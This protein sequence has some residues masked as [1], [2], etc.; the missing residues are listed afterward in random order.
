[1]ATTATTRIRRST[2]AAAALALVLTGALAAG[3]TTPAGA[4]PPPG[5]P[6]KANQWVDPPTAADVRMAKMLTGRSAAVAFKGRLAGIV[7]DVDSGRVVWSRNGSV[8]YMPASTNKLITATNALSTYGANGQ[9]T[10]EVRAGATANSVVVVGSGDPSLSSSQLNRLASATAGRLKEAGQTSA[11]VYVDDD[12]FP[13]PTLAPGWLS[14][15]VPADVAPV[16]G[17]V[18]DQANVPDTS[19]DAGAYFTARLKA[20]GMPATYSGRQ[21]ASPSA[22]L[23]A[24]SK[25]ATVATQISG[26]LLS[27]DNEIAEG[28]HKLVGVARGNGATWSGARVAQYN[29]LVAQGLTVTKDYDGSGLSRADR[30]SPAQLALILARAQ[31]PTQADLWPLRSASAM[32]TAGRTGTLSASYGRFSTAPTSC[33][34][35]RLWAKTGTL[36]DVVALAGYTTATD[37]KR[38]VFAF[39]V[40]GVSSTLTLKRSVDAMAATVVGCY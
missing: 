12:V 11:R 19:A 28:L 27:S 23:Y 17:L 5:A 39:L 16:R 21:N 38:K 26:M 1:M 34:A 37:G 35:G 20:Y 13:T 31:D 29:A 4:L 3:A 30:V 22:T 2:R 7:I 8:G 40:N 24:A 25:G 32:P 10:T 6:P 33:A 15:Y 18:R 36:N 9:F 14:S